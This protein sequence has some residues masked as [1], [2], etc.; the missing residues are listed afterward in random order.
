MHF[1]RIVSVFCQRVSESC[2]GIV[3]QG[4]GVTGGYALMYADGPER[5]YLLGAVCRCRRSADEGACR[6]S[7]MPSLSGPGVLE[8]SKPET[9]NTTWRAAETA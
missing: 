2:F 1:G 6:H 7:V 9:M 3:L 4:V 8:G 5:D